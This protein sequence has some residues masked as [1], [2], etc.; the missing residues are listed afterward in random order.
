VS[1]QKTDDLRVR[2]EVRVDDESEPVQ[3]FLTVVG[4]SVRQVLALQYE[5]GRLESDRCLRIEHG[6]ARNIRAAWHD[7][8][9]GVDAIITSPPYATALPYLDTDRLSLIYLGLLS[10]GDHRTRDGLMVGNREITDRTRAAYRETF[11]GAEGS[12]P[13]GIGALVRR[14]EQ[15][16]AGTEAGF[17]RLNLPALL[18]KY[19]LDMK[20]VLEGMSS[21]LKPGSSA[22][23]V[24]GDNHTIAGGERVEINTTDLLEDLAL[25]VGLR[26]RQRIPM[27]MPTSR[28]IHRRNAV[29][30][31]AVLWLQRDQ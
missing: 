20:D 3:S 5:V 4:R 26:L 25:N 27:E 23:V 1:W 8:L 28:D 2:K 19:F 10:R 13:A 17:R 18:G 12:L 22:F 7:H 30:S 31:E 16:N 29:A 15:L 11:A 6:D 9:D 24:I 14:V 21:V